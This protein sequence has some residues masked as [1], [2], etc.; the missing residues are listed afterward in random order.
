MTPYTSNTTEIILTGRVLVGSIILVGGTTNSSVI[1]NDSTDGS[2]TDIVELKSLANDSK[3][4]NFKRPLEFI[5][6]IYSTISGTGA[7]VYIHVI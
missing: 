1:L 5:N 6:G 3:P 2:G 4:F 7:K